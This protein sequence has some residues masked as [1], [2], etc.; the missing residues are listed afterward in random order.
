MSAIADSITASRPTYGPDSRSDRVATMYSDSVLNAQRLFINIVG[1]GLQAALEYHMV[2]RRTLTAARPNQVRAAYTGVGMIWTTGEVQSFEGISPSDWFQL[3]ASQQ[4][5]K[6]PPNVT[7]TARQKTQLTYSY[8]QCFQATA[9]LYD[10]YG[11]A[12]LLDA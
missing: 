11:S 7:A 1:R 6:S 5:I 10:A 9:L 4:F 3:P 2:Y 12:V 8:T